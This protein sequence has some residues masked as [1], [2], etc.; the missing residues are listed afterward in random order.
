VAVI[1]IYDPPRQDTVE[2]VRRVRAQGVDVK[3]ATGDQRE[4]A[5][6]TCT[7]L[8]MGNNVLPAEAL[9][10]AESGRDALGGRSLLEV[11]EG[12]DGFAG[13]FPQSK[14]RIVEEL[15]KVGHTVAMTG[16]GVNDAPALQ[17]SHVGFAVS[18]ATAA[19]RSAADVVLTS[20]GLSVLV[21]AITG[22]REVF[23]RMRS[24][25]LYAVAITV[26][27]VITFSALVYN[28]RFDMP[29][30]LVLLLALL[31]DGCMLT[32][33]TDA[34]KGSTTPGQWRLVEVFVTGTL[35]GLYLAGSSLVFF[36][37]LVSWD[38]WVD[39]FGLDTPWRVAGVVTDVNY[40]QLHSVV[41]LHTS[42]SRRA[43]IF[44]TRA[45]GLWA[46]S[47][48]GLLLVVAFAA[49]QGDAT[50]ITVYADWGHGG[51]RLGVDG[52]RVGLLCNLVC[53]HRC[54]QVGGGGAVWCPRRRLGSGLPC[55]PRL[56][57]RVAPSPGDGVRARPGW[58]SRDRR[59]RVGRQRGE[60]PHELGSRRRIARAVVCGN[61]PGARGGHG[62]DAAVYCV[63]DAAQAGLRGRR[64]APTDF[65]CGRVRLPHSKKAHGY[66][67]ERACPGLLL[68]SEGADLSIGCASTVVWSSA[69]M[70][71][72]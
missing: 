30:F 3:L 28:W 65:D 44:S 37:T 62:R 56:G 35:Y 21:D 1:P 57:G 13:V 20:P 4:I 18:G 71:V 17:R 49:A 33:S 34:V 61:S 69:Q 23:Q 12:A 11:I 59:P 50:F 36:H 68:S 22:S 42:L 32:I 63:G 52:G 9:T 46:A 27:F 19:A 8:G 67:S 60:P 54:D 47:R 39:S 31:N 64:V 48:P 25:A 41:Y 29:S 66:K 24:Y 70:L 43:L 38:L 55:R 2:K 45:R 26:R 58:T 53:A 16:D 51:H 6:V 5:M 10:V 14:Y 15:Q 72:W 40:P 7:R